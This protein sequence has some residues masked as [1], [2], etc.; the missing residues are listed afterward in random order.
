MLP[1]ESHLS[2]SLTIWMHNRHDTLQWRYMASLRLK[3]P[4]AL[5]SHRQ[6]VHAS[7]KEGIKAPHHWHFD[8]EYTGDQ[9]P[10]QSTSNVESVSMSRRLCILRSG[11]Y[12][13]G[14]N[15]LFIGIYNKFTTVFERLIFSITPPE[16]GWH[17][18]TSILSFW[19]PSLL[20]HGLP[21]GWWLCYQPIR[22][23]YKIFVN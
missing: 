10:S 9:F 2:Q 12:A 22:T 13:I 20:R 16:I 4:A 1:K 11:N 21:I 18:N 6:L 7:D 23:R 15:H 19:H 8:G 17:Y 14:Y 3:S 5:L